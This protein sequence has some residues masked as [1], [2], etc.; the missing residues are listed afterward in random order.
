MPGIL[1]PISLETDIPM[2][3][4]EHAVEFGYW[5]DYLK[6][7]LEVQ[8]DADDTIICH[9]YEK[10]MLLEGKDIVEGSRMALKTKSNRIFQFLSENSQ[11]IDSLIRYRPGY[12]GLSKQKSN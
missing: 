10:G 11:Y 6:R 5:L 3:H 4:L 12:I 8:L 7:Q 2:D 9:L 1:Q